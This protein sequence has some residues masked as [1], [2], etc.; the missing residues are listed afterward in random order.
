MLSKEARNR[1]LWS[2]ASVAPGANQPIHQRQFLSALAMILMP[3][4]LV[5]GVLVLPRWLNPAAPTETF[6]YQAGWFVLIGTAIV[7]VLN[8][9]GHYTLAAPLFVFELLL[10]PAWAGRDSPQMLVFMFVGVLVATA[11]LSKNGAVIAGI[12]A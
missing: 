12:L 10:A 4:A 3:A 6:T 8:R 1:P 7:Y 9:L 11:V 5:A 2:N